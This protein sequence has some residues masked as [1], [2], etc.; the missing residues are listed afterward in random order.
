LKGASNKVI[1][2]VWNEEEEIGEIDKEAFQMLKIGKD[3]NGAP[4]EKLWEMVSKWK[5]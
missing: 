1:I 5:C 2:Q 3:G 4:R